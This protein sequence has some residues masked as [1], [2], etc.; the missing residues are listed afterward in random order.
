MCHNLQLISYKNQ[1][2]AEQ[3]SIKKGVMEGSHQN[4]IIFLTLSYWPSN[5]I[6]AK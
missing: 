6:N 3:I 5:L 4:V 1:A 2:V